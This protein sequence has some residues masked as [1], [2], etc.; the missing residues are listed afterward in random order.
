M[1]SEGEGG[2]EPAAGAT[3]GNFEFSVGDEGGDVAT[4]RVSTGVDGLD[5][6]GSVMATS[7]A[8]GSAACVV[9]KTD[10]AILEVSTYD[11]GS[12]NALRFALAGCSDGAL[13][14]ALGLGA[15]V[16]VGLGVAGV[17]A[18]VAAG[19][20]AGVANVAVDDADSVDVDVDAGA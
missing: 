19:L 9:V 16:G 20:G 8:R 17:S 13:G 1:R 5:A 2:S 10:S 15:N 12:E 18:T 11:G 7:L 3:S 6:V 4:F 14:V